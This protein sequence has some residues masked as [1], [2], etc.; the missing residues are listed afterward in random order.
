MSGLWGTTLSTRLYE[1]RYPGPWCV[2]QAIAP[3]TKIMVYR[4]L[5]QA[6]SNFVR[7]AP[8]PPRP[9]P[10]PQTAGPGRAG[11]GAPPSRINR[12]N[13]ILDRALLKP[14]VGHGPPYRCTRAF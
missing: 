2:T 10:N 1:R 4:N 9:P 7:R 5:A 8:H 12:I 14:A 11:R 6:Y 13:R 3:G